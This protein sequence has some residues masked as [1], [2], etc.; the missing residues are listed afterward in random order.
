MLVRVPRARTRQLFFDIL[1]DYAEELGSQSP[2]PFD[3][4]D[5]MMPALMAMATE[6]R[7]TTRTM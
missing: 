5:A 1:L 4:V 6:V 2:V 7:R 3:Y